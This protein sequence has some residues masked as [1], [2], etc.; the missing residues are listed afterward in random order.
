MKAKEAAARSF[1]VLEAAAVEISAGNGGGGGGGGGVG[2]RI[3]WRTRAGGAAAGRMM[4]TLTRAPH[5]A[6]TLTRLL[7]IATEEEEEEDR[8][9]SEQRLNNASLM[10][11]SGR[12][13]EN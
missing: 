8:P 7:N 9:T 1:R 11:A 5:S 10:N 6:P 13:L 4:S 12:E 2:G 3:T